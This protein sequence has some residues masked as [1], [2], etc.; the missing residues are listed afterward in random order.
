MEYS[1]VFQRNIGLLPP[2]QQQ[3]L[4]DAS[5]AVAGTRGQCQAEA[6]TLARFGVGEIRLIL[7]D[8]VSGAGSAMPD[9]L[10]RNDEELEA[11]IRDTTPYS[12]VERLDADSASPEVLGAFLDKAH[13]VIDT[14]DAGQLDLKT[15]LASLTR[16]RSLYHI[17]THS[18]PM[19]CA[20]IIFPPGGMAL[21]D[22]YE[23]LEEADSSF[24][25]VGGAVLKAGMG[26]TEAALFLTGLRTGQDMVVAPD[27]MV[28]NAFE[29][30]FTR[31]IIDMTDMN[32]EGGRR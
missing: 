9:I 22:F 32:Q 27:F 14:L 2:E 25:T 17:A 11:V 13:I 18:L 29:R 5:V 20:T 8:D 26:A 4:H 21:K 28:F 16:E 12:R 10:G 23:A 3:R 19:G 24:H 7:T 15:T 6:L 31:H 30:R 1:Q